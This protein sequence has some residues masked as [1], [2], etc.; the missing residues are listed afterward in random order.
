M[1]NE[2]KS[3]REALVSA[4]EKNITTRLKSELY[5]SDVN[6][7]SCTKDASTS[8]FLS[9]SIPNH[10]S[11]DMILQTKTNKHFPLF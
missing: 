2:H 3:V 10:Q 4:Y 11:P 8:N 7:Y 1:E 5:N 6:N 9:S